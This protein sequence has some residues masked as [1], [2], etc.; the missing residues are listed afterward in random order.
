MIQGELQPHDL[1]RQRFAVQLTLSPSGLFLFACNR[2][3]DQVTTF[4]VSL[5]SGMVSLTGQYLAVGSPNMIG[6]A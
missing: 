3:S 5:F 6:F 2:R 4:R 1:D